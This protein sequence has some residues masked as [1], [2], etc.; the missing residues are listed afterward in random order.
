MRFSKRDIRPLVLMMLVLVL[1]AGCGDPDEKNLTVAVQEIAAFHRPES[2]AVSLDGRWLFVTNCGSGIYGDKQLF[3]LASRGG[4]VDRLEIGPD[5]TLALAD[6]EFVP[7]ISGPLGIG[8]LPR[9]TKLFKRGTMF[10]NVGYFKQTDRFHRYIREPLRLGTGTLIFDPKTGD[11]L[12]HISYGVGSHI[13]RRRGSPFLVP[14]GLAFDDF[15]NLYVV[16]TGDDSGDV[17]DKRIISPGGVLKIEHA[18]IDALAT[19][20]KDDRFVFMPIPGNPNGIAYDQPTD[21]L[22]VVTCG[23]EADP[24]KG[25][26]YSIPRLQFGPDRLTPPLA[27]GMG[28][29]DG[30]VRTEKGTFIVS[31]FKGGLVAVLPGGRKEKVRLLEPVDYKYASDIKLFRARN[32]RK[33]L[34]MPEQDF[35]SPNYRKQILWRLRLPDRY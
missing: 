8:A 5:G 18:A 27:K 20:K 3:A 33:F 23:G 14:N 17:L 34:L 9:A 22:Y 26:L 29:C 25:A 28:R 30:V 7:R 2:C 35:E 12:G 11:I 31:L 10:V 1:T 19:R 4:S 21:A 32:G 24:M 16:E 6:M 13:A 15:G